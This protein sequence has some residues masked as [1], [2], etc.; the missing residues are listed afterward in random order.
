MVDHR[1]DHDLRLLRRV[2]AVQVDERVSVR[3][4]TFQ[5]REVCPDQLKPVQQPGQ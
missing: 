3:Q 4:L 1:V 5:D 2:R